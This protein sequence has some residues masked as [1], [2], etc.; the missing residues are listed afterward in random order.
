MADNQLWPL[1]PKQ[2]SS[3][4]IRSV[5]ANAT[6]TTGKGFTIANK[7]ELEQKKVSKSNWLSNKNI[8]STANNSKVNPNIANVNNTK[9]TSVTTPQITK[10]TQPTQQGTKMSSLIQWQVSGDLFKNPNLQPINNVKVEQI[11]WKN[12]NL[13]DSYVNYHLDK[14]EIKNM[15]VETPEEKRKRQS[16]WVEKLYIDAYKKKKDWSV[17]TVEDVLWN[18]NYQIILWII[19]VCIYLD[20]SNISTPW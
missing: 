16:E 6:K 18:A 12:Q 4:D 2:T 9:T 14:N 13:S 3:S 10:T 20:Y 1:A 8:V 15:L 11:N 17:L 5:I 19:P 7:D